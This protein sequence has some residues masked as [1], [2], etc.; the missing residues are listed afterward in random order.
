MSKSLNRKL[1][2]SLG[3]L[4]VVVG[5]LSIVSLFSDHFL[6]AQ[7]S[8]NITTTQ[9][10]S[11]FQQVAS[12]LNTSWPWYVTRASGLV[13]AASLVILLLSG[14]GQVTGYTFKFLQPITAWATH[15]ALGLA[16]MGAVITHILA[17]LFDRFIPFGVADL[18]I[19]FVSN[20][21]PATIV[22]I[23]VGSLFVAL[24]ILSLYLTILIVVTSL[25][26]I[27]KKPYFWKL[28]HLLSYAVMA[29]IF[30]HGLFLGTDISSG[31]G[32]VIWIGSAIIVTV[33]VVHRLRRA[34]SI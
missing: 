26:W 15:R 16:F 27:D 1:L 34:N 18:L 29:A 23:N 10:P 3:I 33:A 9:D 14:I 32:R 4:A 30:F 11:L 7:S 20:H 28:I 2:I 8:I 12:R 21:A 22:G 24:G 5:F 25:F 31:W 13:A 17:L 19:P 6:V